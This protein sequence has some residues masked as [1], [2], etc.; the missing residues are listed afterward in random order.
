VSLLDL[1]LDLVF[2]IIETSSFFFFSNILVVA[3]SA[4]VVL[5]EV[6]KEF[7]LLLALF[8]LPLLDNLI[9]LS[10]V[11]EGPSFLVTS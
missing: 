4:L 1:L 2:L 9:F 11:L 10:S 5:A 3:F 7:N 6:L 8:Y